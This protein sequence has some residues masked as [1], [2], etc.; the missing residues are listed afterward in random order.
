M[1]LKTKR[2]SLDFTV[3][4]SDKKTG[5]QNILSIYQFG[6]SIIYCDE[7]LLNV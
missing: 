1:Q 4:L 3:L 5:K 2:V 7:I 6:Y